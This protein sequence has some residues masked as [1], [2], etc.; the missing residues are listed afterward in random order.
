MNKNVKVKINID[1]HWS[2]MVING[3]QSS[4]KETAAAGLLKEETEADV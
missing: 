1:Q 2:N 4:S 3:Y